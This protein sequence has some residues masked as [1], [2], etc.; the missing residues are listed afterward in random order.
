[1]ALTSIRPYHAIKKDVVANYHGAQLLFVGW[2]SHLMFY[3]PLTIAV[4]PGMR[5][6]DL[7]E[8]NLRP[9]FG[10]HPDFEN[11]DWTTV[12]WSRGGMP[13][14]PD[15]DKSLADNGVAHKEVIRFR[16]PGLVGLFG[17]GF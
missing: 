3:S 15:Y 8:A 16:T 4:P 5:F 6:G 14:R 17:C 10:V 13:W 2:D 7:I 12:Q 9:A 11:I 1:M